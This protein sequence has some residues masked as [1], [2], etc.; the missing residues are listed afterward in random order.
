MS[1]AP[2]SVVSESYTSETGISTQ[3]LWADDIDDST[4]DGYSTVDETSLANVSS[5]ANPKVLIPPPSFL[6][7]P[8]NERSKLY[9]CSGLPKINEHMNKPEIKLSAGI[10]M[11]MELDQN[12]FIVGFSK[13]LMAVYSTSQHLKNILGDP[14]HGKLIF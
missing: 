4:L 12:Y 5:S 3:E 10:P 9:S 6:R 11:V 2:P 13:S 8:M 7:G 14:S 1:T